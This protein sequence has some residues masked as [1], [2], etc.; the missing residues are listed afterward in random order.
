MGAKRRVRVAAALVSV[1]AAVALA[2]P[3]QAAP[4][5]VAKAPEVVAVAFPDAGDVQYVGIAVVNRDATR[6]VTVVVRVNGAVALRATTV[7]P[8]AT[9]ERYQQSASN[10]LPAPQMRTAVSVTYSYGFNGKATSR[11]IPVTLH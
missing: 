5:P 2:M 9:L 11:W 7:K 4:A 1:G 3:A 10:T 6:P 8:K